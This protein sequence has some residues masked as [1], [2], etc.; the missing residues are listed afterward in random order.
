M[1]YAPK[2]TQTSPLTGNTLTNSATSNQP[3][4][5]DSNPYPNTIGQWDNQGN[6]PVFPL[7]QGK[8]Q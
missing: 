8:G 5:G 7:F 6:Q 2:T 4:V 3:Q 1:G